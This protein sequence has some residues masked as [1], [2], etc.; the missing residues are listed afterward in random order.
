MACIEKSKRVKKGAS[1][2][3]N[4]TGHNRDI[5][6]KATAA[7]TIIIINAQKKKKSE[8]KHN[9]K[10]KKRPPLSVETDRHSVGNLSSLY[11]AFI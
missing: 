8:R 7:A 4:K 5:I 6:I 2:Q 10:E 9:R 11:S 3:E 1:T